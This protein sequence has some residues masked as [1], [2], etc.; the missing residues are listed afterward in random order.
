MSAEGLR[1]LSLDDLDW[2]VEETRRRRESLVAHAPRFWRP[3]ADA[4]QRHRAF[5]AH[6]VADS[7]VLSV[8]TDHGY[9]FALDQGGYGLVDDMAVSPDGHWATEGTALL[10][11]ALARH[12]RLRLVV[13]AFEQS[14]LGAAHDVGLSPTEIWWHR[15]LEPFTGLAVVTEDRTLS[16]EGATAQLVPAPPVY[17]PGGPIV[18]VTKVESAQSLARV[19]AAS[20]RRGATVSVVSQAPTDA[21]LAS[22]LTSAGYRLTTY[23]CEPALPTG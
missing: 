23:F 8:R 12:A 16:V 20:A 18:L 6:L 3:A 22:L 19:E 9:L 17:D 11:H 7:A 14:R 2:V 1:P 21:D 15:D 4:T 5:L 10:R 13:P